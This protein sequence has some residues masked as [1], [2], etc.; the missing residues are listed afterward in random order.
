MITNFFIAFVAYLCF[1]A[2]RKWSSSWIIA[3]VAM[4][5]VNIQAAGRFVGVLQVAERMGLPLE[6]GKVYERLTQITADILI[7]SAIVVAVVILCHVIRKKKS[8]K[9]AQIP[10]EENKAS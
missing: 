9:A 2:M 10:T 5:I 7:N 6:S 4:F 8:T 1:L 3:L